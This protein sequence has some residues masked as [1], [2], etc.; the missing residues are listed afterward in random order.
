MLKRNERIMN[1]RLLPVF[2]AEK[3][4][5]SVTATYIQPA[6]VIFTE[7]RRAFLKLIISPLPLKINHP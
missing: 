6:L 7:E 1:K 5:I 4:I 3:P 2:T